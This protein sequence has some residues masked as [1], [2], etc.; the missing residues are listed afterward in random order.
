MF[1]GTYAGVSALAMAMAMG[2]NAKIITMDVFGEYW[3]QY[4]A[5]YAIKVGNQ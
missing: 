5:K 2:K 1:L 4:G 3:H